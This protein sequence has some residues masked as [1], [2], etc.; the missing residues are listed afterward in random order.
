MDEFT[1]YYLDQSGGAVH[2][3]DGAEERIG[4]VYRGGFTK[5]PQLGRGF[6][7]NL[8]SGLWSWV[9]PLFRSGAQALGKEALNTGANILS[10]AV[11]AGPSADLKDI[12][13]GRLKEARDKLVTKMR[14][15]GRRRRRTRTR[16]VRRKPVKRVT[17]PRRQSRV[18]RRRGRSKLDIFGLPART[19]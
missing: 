5:G 7:G 8:F 6:L 19:R 4:P 16:S 2:S 9:S 11:T 3:F 14:G 12:T 13:K 1:R 17:R 18:R 15:G 10:D